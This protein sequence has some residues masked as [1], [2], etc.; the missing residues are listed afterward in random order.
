[1]KKPGPSQTKKHLPPSVDTSSKHDKSRGH[2]DRKSSITPTTN[3]KKNA[4]DA[5]H[6]HKQHLAPLTN[7]HHPR[8]CQ[9]DERAET[10]SRA[11]VEDINQLLRGMSL[12]NVA[13]DVYVGIPQSWRLHLVD[14]S[15]VTSS[16]LIQNIA[17]KNAIDKHS[18]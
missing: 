11:K 14:V 10:S 17:S 1:M 15:Q 4:F 7:Q 2:V 5:H 18:C 6:S 8:I 12:V 3:R 13:G 9:I 16:D